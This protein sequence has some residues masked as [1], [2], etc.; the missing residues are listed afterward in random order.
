MTETRQRT[1]WSLVCALGDAGADVPHQTSYQTCP[2]NPTT[3]CGGLN[4][5]RLLTREARP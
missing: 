4:H 3:T 5:R 2:T 1:V